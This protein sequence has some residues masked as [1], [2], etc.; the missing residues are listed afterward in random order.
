MHRSKDAWTGYV[1]SCQINGAPAGTPG[2]LVASLTVDN[3]DPAATLYDG[4]TVFVGST[5]GAHDRGVFYIRD[6]QNVNAGTVALDIGATAEVVGVLQDDDYVVV[7]SEYR[8]WR[9]DPRITEAGGALT[10][11]KEYDRP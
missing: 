2:D 6:D 3:G 4:M 7:L 10:W 9:R 8:I 5:L 1:W 11:Y